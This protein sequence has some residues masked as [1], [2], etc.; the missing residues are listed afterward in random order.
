MKLSSCCLKIVSV[1]SLDEVCWSEE[2]LSCYFIEKCR[3]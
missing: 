2:G 3:V 1:L